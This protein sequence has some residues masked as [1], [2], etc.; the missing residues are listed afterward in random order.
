MSIYAPCHVV[1]MSMDVL[2]PSREPG[3]FSHEIV[4]SKARK[5]KIYACHCVNIINDWFIDEGH[6]CAVPAPPMYERRL[7]VCAEGDKSLDL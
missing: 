6:G 4:I 2:A 5:P 3:C 7:T 1:Q